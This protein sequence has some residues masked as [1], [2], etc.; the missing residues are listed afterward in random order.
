[1]ITRRLLLLLMLWPILLW[2]QSNLIRWNQANLNSNVVDNSAFNQTRIGVN[3]SKA[4]ISS[5]NWSETF[6]MVSDM[7]YS[8]ELNSSHYVQLTISPKSKY[9]IEADK[10]NF[11]YR[12]QGNT[13]K[14]QVRASKSASFDNYF[15][16]ANETVATTSWNTFEQTLTGAGVIKPGEILYIRIYI[17]GNYDN[18]H[19]K[20]TSGSS[21]N[22]GSGPTI[23][24]SYANVNNTM[25]V[26]FNDSFTTTINNSKVLDILNN[27]SFDKISSINIVSQPANGHVVVNG[28]NNVTYTPNI[29]FVGTDIFYYTLTNAKGVSEVTKVTVVVD[30]AVSN[31]LVRWDG[32]NNPVDNKPYFFNTSGENVS[33]LPGVSS[34]PFSSSSTLTVGQY[35][36]Q[37]FNATGFGGVGNSINP[38]YYIQ[39][40]IKANLNYQLAIKQFNFT[41][42]YGNNSPELYQVFYSKSGNFTGEQIQ[43]SK[44]D[45]SFVG[46]IN[47]SKDIQS[48]VFPNEFLLY[49]NEQL[50]VRVYPYKTSNPYYS[51]LY[52]ENNVK[53]TA[54]LGSVHNVTK[55]TNTVTWK[56][57]WVPSAPTSNSA[58][59]IDADYSGD[60][61]NAC[62]V[63]VNS[64]KKI[65]INADKSVNINYNLVNNGIIQVE[66][67][68]NL[69]QLNNATNSG[70]T[71]GTVVVKR[72]ASMKRLDYTYWG[73]PVTGQNVRNLSP[74]TLESR[75][76]VYNE[77]NNY[78]DGLFVKNKYPNGDTSI[79]ATENSSTY[80]FVNA[81]GYAIRASNYAPTTLE[82]RTYSF[83]GVPNNGKI[84]VKINKSSDDKGIN[85]ISNPYPSNIDFDKLVLNNKGKIDHVAYFWTNF[86]PTPS[87]QQGGQYP[88]NGYLNNYAI[89]SASGGVLPTSATPSDIKEPTNVFKVGQGF[90]VQ[91]SKESPLGEIDIDFSNDIRTSSN[92][93][94]FYNDTSKRTSTKKVDRFWIDLKT[95]IGVYSHMLLAYKEGATNKFER[96]YDVPAYIE[97][98]DAIY[99]ILDDHQLLI[100][101]RAFPLSDQDVVPLGASFDMSGIHTISI[102]KKEGIF[103]DSQPI[104]LHDKKLGIYT[105]LQ[106]ESYSFDAQQGTD[107][108]RFEI[109]YKPDSSLGTD[110]NS[111]NQ[112][113]VYQFEE[114]I[115]IDSPEGLSKVIITNA[116]GQTIYQA[117]VK[118]KSAQINASLYPAG[119]YYITVEIPNGSTQT[120][121][122]LKK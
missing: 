16:I 92:D 56:G 18:L 66:S 38:N 93:S 79:T 94:S 91:A 65:I 72:N 8:A 58:V 32:L 63:T 102:T 77:S 44:S 99:S 64:G 27:D 111:K 42:W 26:S 49:S 1:M 29:D 89:Y 12:A 33:T 60:S 96:D 50:T 45:G 88:K 20:Y 74:G 118:G 100:Q 67:D 6:F 112:L 120:K 68:G 21:V 17:Y 5:T 108:E 71:L 87:Q 61:F 25:P 13:V 30:P 86:N 57:A 54:F 4:S 76:Y 36:K 41:P 113:L 90:L 81:K 117:N 22:N 98:S 115:V 114:R 23:T 116:L 107:N 31:V 40:V 83:T 84:K 95:P 15:V 59:I 28:T 119:L 80:T 19:F 51:K 103:E 104:Y 14:F 55:C 105:N 85:L 34:C 24:G 73:S 69:V 82:T 11:Q 3:P 106:N 53:G 9:K 70:A 109:V 121:K 122:I 37:Q 110:H 7:P 75:F 47:S 97:G 39:Y 10:L 35:D 62:S 78:F 48:W 2:S 43:L 46:N 101:G 52:F